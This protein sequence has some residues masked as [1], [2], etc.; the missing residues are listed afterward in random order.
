[1]EQS[2]CQYKYLHNSSYLIKNNLNCITLSDFMKILILGAGS[3]GVYFG[4]L[5][6]S[7]GHNVV[8][9]GRKKLKKLHETIL[10]GY[11]PYKLPERIYKFP[12][13]ISFDIIFIT[14]KLYDLENNLKLIR[15]NNIKTRYLVS[16]QNGIVEDLVYKPYILDT[17]FTSISVFEGFRLVENQ[18]FVS[19]SKTGWKTDNSKIG[20]EISKL[21]KE[22]GINCTSEPNLESLKAE[23]TIMNC[24]INLLSA[25]ERKTFFELY[26]DK[27]TKEIIDSLFDESYNVLKNYAKLKSK[28]ELKRL[29]YDII[30]DMRHYSSTYQDAISGKKTE[31]DFL[32]ALI[33]K[34]GKRYN[35]PTPRNEMIVKQFKSRY[36]KIIE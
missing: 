7:K 34:L 10:I 11:T 23:K 28:E 29:F 5:L 21:L 25:I 1:M 3:I 9:L 8:L 22:T 33:I 26:H 16:I 14:S 30:K 32:N 6:K 27:N 4:T 17:N 12:K 2:K 19:Q 36:K 24:S 13:D 18:L 35:V 15:K 20:I 31:I